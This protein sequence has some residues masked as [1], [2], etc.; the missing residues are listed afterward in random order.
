[1]AKEE[2]K[3][4]KE[5]VVDKIYDEISHLVFRPYEGRDML[6]RKEVLQILDGYK[7]REKA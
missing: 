4:E 7:A 5:S 3:L 6:D 1:M 2:L